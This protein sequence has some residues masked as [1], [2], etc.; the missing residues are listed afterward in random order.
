MSLPQRQRGLLEYLVISD[1]L[2]F[3]LIREPALERLSLIERD[4]QKGLWDVYSE[5]NNYNVAR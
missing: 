2:G 5:T 1:G 3:C 4:K